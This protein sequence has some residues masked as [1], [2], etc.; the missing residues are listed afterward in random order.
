[1]MRRRYI[2]VIG[3]GH[4]KPRRAS[5]AFMVPQ[6][7]SELLICGALTFFGPPANAGLYHTKNVG[8]CQDCHK[9]MTPD[10]SPALIAS[11]IT[12]V[13]QQRSFAPS[14]INQTCLTCHGG[15][16]GEGDGSSVLSSVN[17]TLIRQAGFLNGPSGLAHAGHTL[18]S[19]QQAPGGTWTPGYQGLTCA[20][21]HD[22]HGSEGQY[23]NLVLRPGTATEDRPVTYAIGQNNDPRRDVWIRS[24]PD[25]VGKYDARNIRFNQPQTGRSAYGEWCQG[26]HSAFHGGFRSSNMRGAK[27]WMRHPTA[28]ARIGGGLPQHSSL[29]RYAALSNRVPTL[30]ASGSWPAPD[31]TPSCMSCHKAH[32]NNNPFG[33]L[34]M[35]GQGQLTE[36]GDSHAKG[37]VDLCHQCHTQGL[38]SQSS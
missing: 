10:Q 18:G 37:Y 5:R 11:L 36:G 8:A 19:T 23:R 28:D 29:S 14:D 26:C 34:Y 27:G 31:N 38:S 13:P 22:P 32:G 12:P 35:A 6:I 1:M 33:L 9:S 7:L 3:E 15:R 24:V 17:G 21:C 4:P 16:G 20:D 2:L 30:S 25:A